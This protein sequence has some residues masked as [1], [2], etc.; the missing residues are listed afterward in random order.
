M[1]LFFVTALALIVSLTLPT[2]SKAKEAKSAFQSLGECER[3]FVQDFLRQRAIIKV[4]ST[5][6]GVKERRT[7]L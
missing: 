4:V 7:L 1:K 3:K 6:Y 2:L 5:A